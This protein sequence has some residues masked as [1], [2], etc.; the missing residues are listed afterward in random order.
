[1]SFWPNLLGAV[2]VKDVSGLF[3]A[4]VSGG[5][6]TSYTTADGLGNNVIKCINDIK[7]FKEN[8]IV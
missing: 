7:K 6:I 4:R 1:M 2:F 3:I 5:I 8:Y